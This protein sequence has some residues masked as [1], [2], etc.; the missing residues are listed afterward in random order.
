MATAVAKVPWATYDFTRR[1]E[2]LEYAKL[3][4]GVVHAVTEAWRFERE[5]VAR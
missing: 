5:E 2:A 3:T 4:D 1:Y